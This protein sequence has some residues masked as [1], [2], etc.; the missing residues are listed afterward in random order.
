MPPSGSL[1]HRMRP[2]NSGAI[3]STM[4]MVPSVDWPSTTMYSRSVCVCDSTLRIV[5]PMV[6]WLLNVTVTTDIFMVSYGYCAA[7]HLERPSP[8]V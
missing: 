8:E 2:L 6:R 7:Y 5:S 3:R 1:I 4:A